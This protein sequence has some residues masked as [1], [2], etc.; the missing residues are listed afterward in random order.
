[1]VV[2][3]RDVQGRLGATAVSLAQAPVIQRIDAVDVGEHDRALPIDEH[4]DRVALEP[5]VSRT[6]E[7]S[8]G[9]AT[10][11]ADGDYDGTVNPV[12]EVADLYDMI[13]ENASDTLTVRSVFVIGPDKKVKATLTYPMSTGRNF[14]EILRL[15]DSCQLTAEQQ[16]ATPANWEQ[17]GS[18]IIW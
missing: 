12:T 15:L 5:E 7:S 4:L 8:D 1:M 2:A 17:G 16:L 10:F 3:L 6:R 9:C 13:H 18:V 14:T 11:A